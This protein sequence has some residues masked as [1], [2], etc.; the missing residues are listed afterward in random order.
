MVDHARTRAKF[1]LNRYNQV[2]SVNKT[3]KD[4][5]PKKDKMI[6]SK[7]SLPNRNLGRN[8]TLDSMD[9]E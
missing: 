4:K 2:N 5:S 8:L 6:A 7:F 3:K 1:R 9:L